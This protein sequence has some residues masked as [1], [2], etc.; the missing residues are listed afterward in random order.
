MMKLIRNPQQRRTIAMI[1]LVIGA[2]IF[3]LVPGNA[4]T[5]LLVAGVGVLLEILGIMLKHPD[6]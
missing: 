1:L 4:T 5:G 2:V 6:H 3:L